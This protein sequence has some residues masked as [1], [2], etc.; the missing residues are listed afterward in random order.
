MCVGGVGPG[1]PA[2]CSEQSLRAPGYAAKTASHIADPGPAAALGGA[3][4]RAEGV[5]DRGS[6]QAAASNA[7]SAT[8]GAGQRVGMR[9]RTPSPRLSPVLGRL[10]VS[11]ES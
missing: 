9:S 8:A 3:A 10:G 1:A 11:H 4:L 7:T 6:L 5:D 2:T